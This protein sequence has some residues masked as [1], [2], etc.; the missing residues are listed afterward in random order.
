MPS[1]GNESYN[2]L[3]KTYNYLN[4][5]IVCQKNI[6]NIYQFYFFE[7]TIWFQVSYH[8]RLLRN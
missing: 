2:F 3:T 7:K 4:N 1:L 5:Q 8:K 6:F